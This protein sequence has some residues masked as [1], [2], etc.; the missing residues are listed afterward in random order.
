M[1]FNKTLIHKKWC[2][3]T[4]YL[5]SVVWYQLTAS[6]FPSNHSKGFHLCTCPIHQATNYCRKAVHRS[7][8]RYS[9]HEISC[10]H[11]TQDQL[12]GHLYTGSAVHLVQSISYTH[13]TQDQL[14]GHLFTGWSA[15]HLVHSISYTL[16][17][18]FSC[19]PDIQNE[20]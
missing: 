4:F 18:R 6:G 2:L 8:R 9:L 1:R 13:G 3:G 20:L 7:R 5:S 11:D 17:H 19:T 15:V 16:I 14:G 12:G 10:S